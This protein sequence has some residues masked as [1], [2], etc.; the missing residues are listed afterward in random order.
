MKCLIVRLSKE[1][2]RK[3]KRKYSGTVQVISIVL[4][5]NC[6]NCILSSTKVS[7]RWQIQSRDQI[8]L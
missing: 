8:V 4:R 3:C 5:Q 1:M 7:Y 6:C 2:I